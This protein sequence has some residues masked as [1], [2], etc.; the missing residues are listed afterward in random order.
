MVTQ[1]GYFR[2]RGVNPDTDWLTWRDDTFPKPLNRTPQLI[3]PRPAALNGIARAV[4][5]WGKPRAVIKFPWVRASGPDTTQY[6]YDP[7]WDDILSLFTAL[8]YPDEDREVQVELRS[9]REQR[10]GV[11]QGWA[12]WPTVPDGDG[13]I[14]LTDGA[15]YYKDAIITVTGLVDVTTE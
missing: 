5:A 9:I 1:A 11:W 13:T 8:S 10:W 2:I 6:L 12:Q 15:N 4:G 7:S 3:I 14:Q